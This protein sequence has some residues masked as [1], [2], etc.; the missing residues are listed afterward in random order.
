M[1]DRRDPITVRWR[2]AGSQTAR[3]LRFEPR[4]GGWLRLTEVWTGCAWRTEGS[5]VV[6]DMAVV[7]PERVVGDA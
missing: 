2:A 3:R 7:G 6:S 1:T 5:E 4:E